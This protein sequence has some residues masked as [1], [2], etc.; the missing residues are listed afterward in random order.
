MHNHRI[1][2]RSRKVVD[3]FDQ[4]KRRSSEVGELTERSEQKRAV[5]TSKAVFHALRDYRMLKVTKRHKLAIAE[6]HNVRRIM[7]N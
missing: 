6:R 7:V 4:L 1:E 2:D 5:I 3:S